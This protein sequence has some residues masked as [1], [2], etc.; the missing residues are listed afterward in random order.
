MTT[1]SPER[2]DWIG[3]VERALAPLVETPT[4]HRFGLPPLPNGDYRA[5]AATAKIDPNA[6]T[7]FDLFVIK[8]NGDPTEMVE[9]LSRHPAIE[10]NAAGIGEE[11]ATFVEMPSKGFRLE[12]RDLARHLTRSAVVRGCRA[13][14]AHLER[15]LTLSAE[16][17]VPGYEITVF[18]GLL[19]E[20]EVVIAPG[21]EI[22][23]YTR[24]E[25]ALIPGFDAWADPE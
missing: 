5:L 23:S 6:R 10:P 18:R 4:R 22:V 8:L 9:L 20:S 3:A 17:R 19:M 14:V 21:L 7:T 16:G 13:A 15:F 25:V 2:I 1:A 24:A 12:L 11:L